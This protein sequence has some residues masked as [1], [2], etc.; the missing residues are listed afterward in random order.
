[1]W[2]EEP[3]RHDRVYAVPEVAKRSPIP[4][5][6]GE[7]F[8][9]LGEFSE[10]AA[11]GGV[12]YWQPEAAHLGGLG[13]LKAVAALCE[14]NDGVLAPHQ[15]GGPV[16]TA[17]CLTLAACTNNHV[18]QEHFDAFNE[19]WERDIVSW[20]AELD[21]DGCLPIPTAPGIGVELNLE[22][23]KKHPYHQQNFLPI[24]EDGWERRRSDRGGA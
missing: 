4:I 17:V 24:F 11:A 23:A 7:S 14:A 6:T 3:V 16:A 8:H 20:T 18:I 19:P 9:T 15:A 12:A 22:E 1:M 10:M 21:D 13:P 5:A 2:F